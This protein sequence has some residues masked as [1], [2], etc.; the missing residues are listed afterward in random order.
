MQIAHVVAI[1]Q[2]VREFMA[3]LHLCLL[4]DHKEIFATGSVQTCVSLEI[5]QVS[6]SAALFRGQR[7]KLQLCN[8]FGFTIC[9]LCF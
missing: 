7:V 4:E 5:A 9:L 6:I 1:M 2:F 3:Y 8:K